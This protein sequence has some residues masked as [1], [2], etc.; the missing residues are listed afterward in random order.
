M[1]TLQITIICFLSGCASAADCQNL[2]ILP[3][4]QTM[5]MDAAISF[6]LREYKNG[7]RHFSMKD[8]KQSVDIYYL[9]GVVL[10]QGY[11]QAQIE[12]FPAAT[13]FMMPMAFTVPIA[14]LSEAVPK[15]PCSVK[16][17]A[18]VV[19]PLS[20]SMRLQDRKLTN[21]VVELVPF[22]SG[23]V[24]YQLDVAIDPP[25]QNKT[26][27]RYSGTMS[28]VSQQEA[29]SEETDVTGY[30]LV[31]GSRPFLVAGSTGVPA[32]LGDLRRFLSARHV[33][34]KTAA[35]ETLRHNDPPPPMNRR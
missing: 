22:A 28:F 14:V 34:P 29:P 20:G 2:W 35:Q 17:K 31:T 26:S 8:S 27:V 32:K 9:K 6:S 24:S 3:A 13:L 15:G 33:A 4:S 30:L 21:A 19:V 25:A 12:Q 23:E 11:S 18:S 16:G 7:E 5:S 1:H 10:V